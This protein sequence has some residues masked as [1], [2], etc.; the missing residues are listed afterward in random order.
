MK[1]EITKGEE[2]IESQEF[3]DD[4][5]FETLLMLMNKILDVTDEP[6]YFNVDVPCE[7]E[8]GFYIENGRIYVES[9][10]KD[11]DTDNAETDAENLPEVEKIIQNLAILNKEAEEMAK[12]LAKKYNEDYDDILIEAEDIVE[13]VK[14]RYADCNRYKKQYKNVFKK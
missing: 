6:R 10:V 5:H 4:I 12:K 13:A 9:E 3:V 8:V 1:K 14:N 11:V 7:V 2:V